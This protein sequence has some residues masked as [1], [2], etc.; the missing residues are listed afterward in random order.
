MRARA[1]KEKAIVYCD[2]WAD[3]LADIAGSIVKQEKWAAPSHP[4]NT[5]SDGNADR[6]STVL[7]GV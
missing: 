6:K 7:Q 5:T 3:S 4:P 2:G 1:P